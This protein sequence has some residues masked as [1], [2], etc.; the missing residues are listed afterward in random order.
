MRALGAGFVRG[1]GVGGAAIWLALLGSCGA[2]Q[3]NYDYSKEPNPGARGFVLG[4][5]DELAI[6]VWKNPDLTTNATIRPDGYVTMP[7][8]GDLLAAG[9]TPREL[10]KAIEQRIGAYIK[11]Q[12]LVLTVAVTAVRSYHFIVSGQ[13]SR[14]GLFT[15]N[16]YITVAEAMAMAGG[17]TRFARQDRILIIRRQG[18]RRTIPINYETISE[19]KRPEMNLHLLAGDTIHVP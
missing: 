12:S 19:G 7:L 3:L 18:G 4:P 17:P 6:A 14:P 15:A 5:S 8:V 2:T 9:K 1:I 11:D 13:V 10:R 16:R